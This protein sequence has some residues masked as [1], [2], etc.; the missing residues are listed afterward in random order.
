MPAYPANSCIDPDHRGR[1]F[2]PY[3]LQEIGLRV[4]FSQHRIAQ[5]VFGTSV[6]LSITPL[7]HCVHYSRVLDAKLCAR[8]GYRKLRQVCLR[9]W[10]VPSF[11]LLR[12]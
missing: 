5:A 11:I 3:L 6:P 12:S 9:F 4:R 10:V 1:R 2:T 7:A 8:T